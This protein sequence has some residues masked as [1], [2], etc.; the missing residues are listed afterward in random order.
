MFVQVSQR[1]ARSPR[2]IIPQ[3]RSFFIWKRVRRHLI[4]ACQLFQSSLVG[5]GFFV[6]VE[7]P[8]PFPKCTWEL[9]SGN[10]FL[11]KKSRRETKR[12]TNRFLGKN[13]K[14]CTKKGRIRVTTKAELQRCECLCVSISMQVSRD[15]PVRKKA[16]QIYIWT[17][18]EYAMCVRGSIER[19]GG[20]GGGTNFQ[21]WKRRSIHAHPSLPK[22]T[23][24]EKKKGRTNKGKKPS[25]PPPFF[26][27]TL[28]TFTSFLPSP[29]LLTATPFCPYLE[30]GEICGEKKQKGRS[31]LLG[32]LYAY[33][34]P[35]LP[36]P[37]VPP[38]CS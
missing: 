16:P 25:S 36:F 27:E 9:R 38:Y 2:C 35:P 15:F 17:D 12:W 22:N 34:P 1:P 26:H 13:P 33:G 24:M 3:T 19:G 8:P 31:P 6:Y 29:S 4:G 20:G 11:Q 32:I 18:S 14:K 28:T 21:L 10:I 23:L 7:H 37:T 30:E 5:L